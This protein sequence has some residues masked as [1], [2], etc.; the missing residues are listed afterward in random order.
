MQYCL[1]QIYGLHLTLFTVA[2]KKIQILWSNTKIDLISENLVDTRCYFDVARS[3]RKRP[4]LETKS[5]KLY[6]HYINISHIFSEN[7]I[8]IPQ[9]VQKIW[10][11]SPL[12][13]TIF[14]N[15]LDFLKFLITKKQ[16]TWMSVFFF[17]L[18]PTLKMLFN[19]CTRLYWY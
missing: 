1:I 16:T 2:Y 19:N 13:L 7:V 8:E 5:T 14:I 3:P 11:F 10:R 18:Q 15:V 12:I 17:L 4:N 9:V 6:K